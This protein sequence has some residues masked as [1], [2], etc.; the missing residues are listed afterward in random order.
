MRTV[1]ALLVLVLATALAGCGATTA[2]SPARH[3]FSGALC[4]DTGRCPAFPTGG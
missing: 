4:K 1:S 3:S 2:G